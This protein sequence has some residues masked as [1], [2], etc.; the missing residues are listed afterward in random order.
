MNSDY[1]VLCTSL[2]RLVGSMRCITQ[3][4]VKVW[5][6]GHL[7]WHRTRDGWTGADFACSS[8]TR[9]TG[10]L[11]FTGS[12]GS[13]QELIR[14]L[15]VA[16]WVLRTMIDRDPEGAA[17][18]YPGSTAP[19]PWWAS[20]PSDHPLCSPAASLT[21]PPP[22]KDLNPLQEAASAQLQKTPDSCHH[23]LFKT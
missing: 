8:D 10:S 2:G 7:S 3:R 16:G 4:A 1:R 20:G 9:G 6:L 18:A 21:P 23:F 22:Q 11:I 14:S 17:G 5:E 15:R 12:P 19:P 13:S